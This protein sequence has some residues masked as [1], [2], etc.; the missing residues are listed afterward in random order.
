MSR[1]FNEMVQLCG[2]TA[3]VGPA[4]TQQLLQVSVS[5]DLDIVK[6][7]PVMTFSF[8]A[9]TF[10]IIHINRSNLCLVRSVLFCSKN[11]HHSCIFRIQR[12]WKLSSP[13]LSQSMTTI[14]QFLSPSLPLQRNLTFSCTESNSFPV[15]FNSTSFLRLPGQSDSDTLSVSLSFR[16]WNPNGLLMFT[17]LADGW[18]EVGLTEGKVSVYMNVTQRKN[19]RIDISSGELSILVQEPSVSWISCYLVACLNLAVLLTE[20]CFCVQAQVWMMASGTVSIWMP[21]RTM[22][23][24]LWME[25]KH[26]QSEQPSPFKSRLQEPTTLEVTNHRFQ[27]CGGGCASFIVKQWTTQLLKFLLA[28]WELFKLSVLPQHSA[29]FHF[30]SVS[31]VLHRNHNR[32]YLKALYTVMS[33]LYNVI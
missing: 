11:F 22:Q 24:W 18:V 2:T 17:A 31:F 28:K 6:K 27:F 1:F 9:L 13:K 25:M 33:W 32:R 21:W 12:K 26:L 19:T 10:L 4:L 23:C 20:V 5:A 16:T 7:Q 3:A 14:P 15:F 29:T 30:N 8:P